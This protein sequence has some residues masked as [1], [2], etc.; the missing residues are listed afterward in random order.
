M[1]NVLSINVLIHILLLRQ[2]RAEAE[3]HQLATNSFTKLLKFLDYFV[4]FANNL[5]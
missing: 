4:N 2:C 1:H 5:N 3:L